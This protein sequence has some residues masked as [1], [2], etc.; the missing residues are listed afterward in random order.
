MTGP[1]VTV[2]C[3]RASSTP[4]RRHQISVCCQC[5]Q[6]LWEMWDQ[7]PLGRDSCNSWL[8]PDGEGQLLMLHVAVTK[9]VLSKTHQEGICYSCLQV[10]CQQ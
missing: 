7:A 10:R 5:Y 8:S 4:E 6:T 1:G 9:L 3:L 2:S